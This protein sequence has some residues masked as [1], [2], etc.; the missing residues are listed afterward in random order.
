ML[1]VEGGGSGGF[2]PPRSSA[3]ALCGGVPPSS[4]TG[5]ESRGQAFPPRVQERLIV[6][7]EPRPISSQT[8]SI[9]GRSPSRKQ[10]SAANSISRPETPREV[11][12]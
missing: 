10:A 1:E 5:V 9:V 11:R 2:Q 6:S 3:S 4:V 8:F 12:P 7:G